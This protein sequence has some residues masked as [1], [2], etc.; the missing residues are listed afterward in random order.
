MFQRAGRRLQC[1]RTSAELGRFW[2][3]LLW[4]TTALALWGCVSVP[5]RDHVIHV[6]GGVSEIVLSSEGA[7]APITLDGD[8]ISTDKFTIPFPLPVDL[9][10][11]GSILLL[12]KGTLQRLGRIPLKI[13]DIGALHYTAG[14][15]VTPEQLELALGPSTTISRELDAGALIDV[16]VHIP[17]MRWHSLDTV[18][19]QMME[20]AGANAPD[21]GEA[22]FISETITAAHIEFRFR[23][24]VRQ[25]ISLKRM[26]ILAAHLIDS[27]QWKDAEKAVLIREFH[28]PVPI[29]YKIVCL[30]NMKGCPASVNAGLL[31]GR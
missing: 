25:H 22:M 19:V 8:A 30:D 29:L 3:W 21:S 5:A 26:D 28:Q 16:I 11:P 24:V 14:W 1:G 20:M 7:R 2:P 13:N 12:G 10:S 23:D 31:A 9:G 27:V 15:R 17:T 6:Q 18:Y 4:L